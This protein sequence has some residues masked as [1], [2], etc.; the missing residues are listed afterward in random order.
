[1][2]K[3][4]KILITLGSITTIIAGVS[5]PVI[6]LSTKKTPSGDN[7]KK[8]LQDILSSIQEE[9][10]TE[11][12]STY[13]GTEN[14]KVTLPTNESDLGIPQL[15]KRS[16]TISLSF[17][18]IDLFNGQLEI[19]A[20]VKVNKYEETK[21]FIVKGY[22]KE[23]PYYEDL[24]KDSYDLIGKD[25]W[26]SLD[27]MTSEITGSLS[28]TQIGISKPSNF[29]NELSSS[30]KVKNADTL[31]GKITFELKLSKVMS[32]KETFEKSFDVLV[33]GFKST[34]QDINDINS[35][36]KNQSYE[37]PTSFDDE[38]VNTKLQ[39]GNSY[40]QEQVGVSLSITDPTLY[41][42]SFEIISLDTAMGQALAKLTIS[43]NSKSSY[44]NVLITGFKSQNMEDV[45]SALNLFN[46]TS[47]TNRVLPSSLGAIG[48]IFTNEQIGITMPSNL[49]GVSI[50][51]KLDAINDDAGWIIVNVI[52]R[53]GTSTK[54]KDITI[55]NFLTKDEYDVQQILNQIVNKDTSSIDKYPSEIGNVDE[56]KTAS[57]LGIVDVTNTVSATITYKIQIVDD[58]NGTLKI[59]ASVS[60]G[61]LTPLKKSF[62]IS[63]Y[64]SIEKD[65]L[66][67]NTFLSSF[68]SQK[69]S[70][71]N[72]SAS[73][74]PVVGGKVQL[75]DLGISVT[76]PSNGVTYELNVE[77]VNDIYGTIIIN[78]VANKGKGVGNKEITISGFKSVNIPLEFENENN[79]VANDNLDINRSYFGSIN[80]TLNVDNVIT[81][82]EP[83]SGYIIELT[84]GVNFVFSTVTNKNFFAGH[85]FSSSNEDPQIKAK[86]FEFVRETI[87]YMNFGIA[88]SVKYNITFVGT[89]T[90]G[91]LGAT[92]TA[93]TNTNQIYINY[94]YNNISKF[95]DRANSNTWNA[96]VREYHN[97]IS[98][99]VHE[100]GHM[101]AEFAL[102]LFN[103]D[104]KSKYNYTVN[105]SKL[106]TSN[107]REYDG[108]DVALKMNKAFV[109]EGIDLSNLLLNMKQNNG[110]LYESANNS[111]LNFNLPSATQLDSLLTNIYGSNVKSEMASIYDDSKYSPVLNYFDFKDN[112]V[113]FEKWDEDEDGYP[114]GKVLYNNSRDW[115]I[116]FG[117]NEYIKQ[118]LKYET[119]SMYLFNLHEFSTRMFMLL[120]QSGISNGLSVFA[121]SIYGMMG[122]LLNVNPV[123]GNLPL[124]KNNSAEINGNSFSE[125]HNYFQNSLVPIEYQPTQFYFFDT[126]G[127][128][129]INFGSRIG[130][131][132]I[133]LIINKREI[134]LEK[135][136]EIFYGNYNRAAFNGNQYVT[137]LDTTKNQFTALWSHLRLIGN[138]TNQAVEIEWKRRIDKDW[139]NYKIPSSSYKR[140]IY[141]VG[142]KDRITKNLYYYD[143]NVPINLELGNVFT[144]DK[145]DYYT[146]NTNLISNEDIQIRI[147]YGV[148]VNNV[149]M[150][151][152]ENN[153]Y[154]ERYFDGFFA[155]LDSS[156]GTLSYSPLTINND[157]LTQLLVKYKYSK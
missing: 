100:S 94:T 43:K 77:D 25:L 141:K 6:L 54:S 49:N 47:T 154:S 2:K 115:F 36:L 34:D 153:Y 44:K 120:S 48:N 37:L 140:V 93:H 99:I 135:M 148:F 112:E 134:L 38:Y 62:V 20:K 29:S 157:D 60:K 1:M 64:R 97:A 122:N 68:S 23:V 31:L 89:G 123:P 26:T 125:F 74:V 83:L 150:W 46:N 61:N 14:W 96:N 124:G 42:A 138:S 105:G 8:I 82:G 91:T 50:S 16:G 147:K 119:S 7:D 56:I 109:D 76:T 151:G 84:N 117:Y 52:A 63:K 51:F 28:W 152:L 126:I 79:I 128:E 107:V 85:N 133:E 78:V 145:F 132:N 131:D 87:S 155:S 69:T 144:Q 17:K 19:N 129:Y 71:T 39:V 72:Q 116:N 73:S 118:Y 22:K 15:D 65:K 33:N 139:N 75:S 92:N 101:E 104:T 95:F 9:Y 32:N 18:K 127:K 4:T 111:N 12:S 11:K 143:V 106:F 90:G 41:D 30:F 59:E 45:K 55:T 10:T 142:N 110:Y 136:L 113:Y 102:G 53:K 108:E 88:Q 103:D 80:N 3:K 57:E 146:T 21:I 98:T 130:F 149:A 70:M 66:D 114:D 13:I 5:I 81:K 27:K 156:K 67:I 58:Q 86:L 121:D 40:T 24:S 35:I 137:Q